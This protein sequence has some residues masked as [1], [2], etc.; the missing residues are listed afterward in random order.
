MLNTLNQVEDK[1]LNRIID[2][3]IYLW[4]IS[5]IIAFV[6]MLKRG[7]ISSFD[8]VEISQ[9]VLMF[10]VWSIS[11]K[12]HFFST[13]SKG[14]FIAFISGC[15]AYLGIYKY[16][17]LAAGFSVLPLTALLICLYLDRRMFWAFFFFNILFLG[18]IALG[19]ATHQVELDFNANE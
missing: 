13:H 18:L 15:M 19:Y 11:I 4:Q 8:W 9:V 2:R 7:N 5:S 17:L 1:I 6:M 10:S 3:F 16:G 14:V 12:P